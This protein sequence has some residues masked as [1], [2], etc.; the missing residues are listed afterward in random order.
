[1]GFGVAF[2]LPFLVAGVDGSTVE[3]VTGWV[4]GIED[5]GSAAGA[6][7]ET[8]GIEGS[9]EVAG[10]TL[11][12]SAESAGALSITEDDDGPGVLDSEGTD[13][14]LLALLFLRLLF[15]PLMD[16]ETAFDSFGFC[17]KS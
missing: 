2:D 12:T 6:A 17:F 3:L 14:V 5:T 8:S 9:A 15:S 1:M 13:D 7:S 10:I 16:D 4:A 11:G